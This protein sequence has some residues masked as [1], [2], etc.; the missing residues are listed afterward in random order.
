[1]NERAKVDKICLHRG[2]TRQLAA[3]RAPPRG[4]FDPALA[5]GVELPSRAQRCATTCD[6][7]QTNNANNVAPTTPRVLYRATRDV[8]VLWR[9]SLI[10]A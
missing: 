8:L 5:L 2:Q 9:V 6:S 4:L 1:M 7:T 10:I 3:H